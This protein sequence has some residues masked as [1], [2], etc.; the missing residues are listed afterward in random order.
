[1]H[2]EWFPVVY[3]EEFYD[4][5]VLHRMPHSGEPLYTCVATNRHDP[6]DPILACVVGAVVDVQKLNAASRQLLISDT[7]RYQRLFYIMTLGT[8]TEY[9]HYGLATALIQKCVQEVTQDP[10]CGALYLHVITINHSAIR[11]Y[12]R[13]GFWRVQEI[14]DYYTIDGQNYN[15]YLYAKY[16]HGTCWLRPSREEHAFNGGSGERG[17]AFSLSLLSFVWL[18]VCLVVSFFSP[19]ALLGETIDPF[20]SHPFLHYILAIFLL[21]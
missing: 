2:E 5:L 17:G 9:R 6:E 13:L 1:M 18:F 14:Q 7:R 16:F 19:C 4:Q 8:V 10:Q 15:C 21:L 12:E 20:I 11:F 3:Q